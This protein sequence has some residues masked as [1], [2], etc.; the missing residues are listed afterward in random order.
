MVVSPA[1]ETDLQKKGGILYDIVEDTDITFDGLRAMGVED[2]VVDAV[3][4]LTNREEDSYE[5][6]IKKIV[7]SGNETA[8]Q[9]KTP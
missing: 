5:D 9:A 8:I 4:L 7:L 1:G 3:D 6:Y 2:E